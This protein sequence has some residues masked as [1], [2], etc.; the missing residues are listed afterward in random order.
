MFD[1]TADV[2]SDAEIGGAQ[3]A[4]LA[5]AARHNC[6]HIRRI[7]ALMQLNTDLP[8][9]L[10]PAEVTTAGPTGCMQLLREKVRD[11]T[12]DADLDVIDRLIV[13][14][15]LQVYAQRDYQLRRYDGDVCLIVPAGK[16]VGLESLQIRPYVRRLRH[17]VLPLDARDYPRSLLD[18][19]P[20][21][22]VTHYVCMRDDRFS[23]ALAKLLEQEIIGNA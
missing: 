11:V 7:A 2:E 22:L 1:R 18:A 3:V 23:Q 14:Y 5:E 4:E 15:E 9:D 20:G 10:D 13:Q 12:P 6:H 21:E 8:F 16:H 17:W 19:F